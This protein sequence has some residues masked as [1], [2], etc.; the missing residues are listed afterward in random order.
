MFDFSP[1]SSNMLGLKKDEIYKVIEKADKKGDASWW[2][3]EY[4]NKK[5]YVPRSYLK[6][7][8]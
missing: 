5:G 1:M 4:D 6:L 8:D 7:L 3:L 2:L